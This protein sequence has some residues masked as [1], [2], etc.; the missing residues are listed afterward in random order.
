MPKIGV[1][2]GG[3]ASKGAYEIGV[4][5]AI[6][7]YFGM[8]SIHVVS[9]SSIGALVAQAYGMDQTE[10]MAKLWKSMDTNKHG[11]F[12]LSYSGN[13]VLLNA[14]DEVLAKG[15]PLPYEHY[16]SA[17]NYTKHRVEYVPFHTL[18]GE[19]LNKFMHGAIAIPLF[20]RGEKIDGDRYLDGAFLDNIPAYPLLE[21]DLDFIFCVYF[22]NCNYIFENEEFDKKIIKLIDFPNTQRLELMKY[23]ADA[24]DSMVEYGYNYA[25]RTIKEIFENNSDKEIYDAIEELEKNR[26]CTY[27]P[28]LTADIVLDNINVVTKRYAKRMSNR[29]IKSKSNNKSPKN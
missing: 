16:V 8:D 23:S 21:K 20:S 18:E 17:W 6:E 3:G 5:Q 22:D 28:R 10:E 12:F 26:E 14:I 7:E 4:M 9:S 24:F 15:K 27:K 2:L 11:R 29:E 1:V 19:K 25:M 13:K